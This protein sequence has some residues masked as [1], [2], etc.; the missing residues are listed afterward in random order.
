MR[1]IR[2]E[3]ELDLKESEIEKFFEYIRRMSLS[4]SD[5]YSMTWKEGYKE[6]DD[7]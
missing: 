6:E 4:Y 1:R 3:I 2:F 7:A 5:W